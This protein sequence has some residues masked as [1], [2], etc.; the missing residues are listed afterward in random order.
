MRFFQGSGRYSQDLDLDVPGF[1]ESALKKG[2]LA[3]LEAADRILRQRRFGGVESHAFPKGSGKRNPE[4]SVALRTP[5]DERVSTE[6]QFSCRTMPLPE[7]IIT[8]TPAP[9][10]LAPGRFPAFL[11]PTYRREALMGLKVLA[12]VDR[13]RNQI[14]DV[15]D[16]SL[17]LPVT[18][19]PLVILKRLALSN[20]ALKDAASWCRSRDTNYDAYLRHIDP[21][22]GGGNLSAASWESLREQVSETLSRWAEA[23]DV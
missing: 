6:I 12:L 14:R 1:S 23:I 16:M 8:Q 19:P 10:V 22:L 2:A 5:E 9:D 18:T 7:T 3:A 15:F 21:Y 4:M 17:F 13:N 20:T 11:L